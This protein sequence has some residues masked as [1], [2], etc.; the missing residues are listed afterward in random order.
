MKTYTIPFSYTVNCTIPV[1]ASSLDE[2]INKTMTLAEVQED[3][4][5]RLI[6]G[7]SP[8]IKSDIDLKSIEVNDELAEE[9]NPKKTYQVTIR[10][11]QTQTVY[12]EAHSEDDACEIASQN[13][14]SSEYHDSDFEDEESE[15]I[16]PEIVD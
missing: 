11:V 7:F 9:L 4:S 3:G 13:Y 16:D 2:A 6:H 10:R 8:I 1:Q 15:A 14:D 12:V 5:C